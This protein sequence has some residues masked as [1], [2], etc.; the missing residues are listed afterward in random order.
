MHESSFEEALEF[1]R[2]KDSRY[3]RDAYLFV[4]EALDH[5]QETI[6]KD[7]RGRSRHVTG[8]ELLKGIRELGVKKYGP[9][10]LMLFQ[11]WGV[12]ACKD[13]GE[14]VFNM[15]ETGGCPTFVLDDLKDLT[16][17]VAR[18][19]EHSEPV[20]Q[21]VWSS[22]SAVTREAILTDPDNE[23]IGTMLVNDLNTIIGNPSLYEEDRF[24]SVSLSHVTKCLLG[25]DFKGDHLARFNRLLLEDA[26]P[27][28]ILK[29]HG[30]LAK[31]DQDSRADFDNGYEFYEAFQKPFLPASK[32]ARRPKTSPA[33]SSS[34]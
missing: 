17:F 4:R 15:V 8:Q 10:A 6:A 28:D 7:S 2:K 27:L 11:E 18:L 29:S 22:L 5:T 14:I 9:M 20:S 31:T 33:P 25:Q 12:H 34:V 13:F 32:Q 21:F 19:K 16:V 24:A 30:V 3:H 26:Y 23:A 1:I